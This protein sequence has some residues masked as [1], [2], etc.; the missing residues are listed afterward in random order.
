MGRSVD[1][2]S[3]AASVSYA[4]HQ[5]GYRHPFNEEKDQ[6]DYDADMEFCQHIAEE[7]WSDFKDDLMTALNRFYPSLSVD[8]DARRWE[9]E[10]HIIA[11]NRFAEVGL[12]EYCGLLS[13]SIRAR[14]DFDLYDNAANLSEQWVSQVNLDKVLADAMG[15]DAVLKRLGTMSNGSGVF[16]RAA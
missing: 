1:Y 7:D 13:L 11:R 8:F 12:A 6:Y 16:Q 3:R 2:L 15:K 5:H 10:T 4:S 14:E 9:G